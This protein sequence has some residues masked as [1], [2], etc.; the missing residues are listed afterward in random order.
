MKNEGVQSAEK[1]IA[2]QRDQLEIEVAESD[3]Y[4]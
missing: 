2:A 3:S 1:S 4:R